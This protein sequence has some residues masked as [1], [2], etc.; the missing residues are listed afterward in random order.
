MPVASA[1]STGLNGCGGAAYR[2]EDGVR[3]CNRA[4][5]RTG[6]R[7]ARRVNTRTRSP[8]VVLAKAHESR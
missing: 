2:F 3:N 4:R 8:A 6:A 7:C 5:A 1:G